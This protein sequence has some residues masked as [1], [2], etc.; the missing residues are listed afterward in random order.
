MIFF[1]LIN[2]VQCATI[3]SPKSY[4]VYIAVNQESVNVTFSCD[5]EKIIHSKSPRLSFFPLG[6]K[7]AER[8]YSCYAI[9]FLSIEK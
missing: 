8:Y 4:P 9:N 2:F 7:K 3:L 5:K 6:F 1:V